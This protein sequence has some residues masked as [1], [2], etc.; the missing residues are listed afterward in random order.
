MPRS[1]ALD[2]VAAFEATMSLI[3][4]TFFEP[5]PMIVNMYD[6]QVRRS[7]RLDCHANQEVSR[8][9]TRGESEESIAHRQ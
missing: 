4:K 5:Q 7:K 6:L 3:A 9:R 8:C 2:F 1:L